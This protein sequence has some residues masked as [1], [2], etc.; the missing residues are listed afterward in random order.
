[1]SQDRLLT[2]EEWREDG[3]GRVQSDA[4]GGES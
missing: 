1:M 4:L 2:A 3:A